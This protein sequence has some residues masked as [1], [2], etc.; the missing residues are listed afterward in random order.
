MRVLLTTDTVGGVWTFTRELTAGLLAR[1]H[2]VAL[3][4]FGRAPSAAQLAWVRAV[5]GDFEFH[6]GEAPLEWMEANEHA[7]DG[8]ALLERVAGEFA[9]D[10]L[11][12]SQFCYGAL[13]GIGAVV[14]TAHSDVLSWGEACRPGGLED[15]AWLWRYRELVQ[16]G[17]D[18]ADGVAAPTEW[19]MRALEVNFG[20][21]AT[22]RVILN[23]R[24]VAVESAG[25]T[26]FAAVTAGRLWD[27]A[28]GLGVLE[29]LRLPFPFVV[30]G[31]RGG[32]DGRRSGLEY[33][34]SLDERELFALFRRSSVY[35]AASVYEPFGLAP[36]EAAL[37]GCAVVA[38][39]LASLREV[40]GDSA[41]YFNGP[42]ELELLL[43]RLAAD[44]EQLEAARRRS[45]VRARELTGARMTEAYLGLYAEVLGKGVPVAD[46][47]VYAH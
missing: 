3:V 14:V 11:H 5:R 37:C 33:A 46:R 16:Q 36:L 31:E 2:A 21:P 18:G 7:M 15:S 40:W 44:W 20:L 1:G 42:G 8:G 39:D 22:R 27:E 17:L 28:K 24:D 35:V 6:A 30:A 13:K 4:S 10:V 38:N 26:G 45:G 34:G 43:L 29:G 41:L 9:P 32:A 19:M 47:L 23:G 12:T 25:G